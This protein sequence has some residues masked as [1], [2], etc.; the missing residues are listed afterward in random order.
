[1]LENWRSS[2][3]DNFFVADRNLQRLLEFYWGEKDYRAA[4]PD[5][6]RFGRVSATI[7][8]EAAR[9]SNEGDHLPQLDR[10][11][12]IGER[13]EEVD[14]HPSYHVAGRAIYGS[15]VMSVYQESGK[16][17]HSLA[18]FYLSGLNGEA[19][20]NCPLAMTAGLIKVLQAVGSPALQE[21]Y[22]PR[23]LEDDYDNG[24]SGAQFLTEVQG[25]SDVGANATVATPLDPAAEGTW[26]LNG[27]KWFCSN[28]TADL[29]LVTARVP[30][31]GEG[32]AGLGLFLAPRRLENGDLN[33]IYFRRLK[34]KLGTRSLATGEVEFDDALAYQ[35][36]DVD[37]G[38]RHA[39]IYVINTS[40]IFNGV[41]DGLLIWLREIMLT[42]G[43]IAPEDVDLLMLANTPEEAAQL[44]VDAL[45]DGGWREEQEERALAAT[46]QVYQKE[47][48]AFE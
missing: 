34:D 13:I 41:G 30:G 6:Y 39:M 28:L 36:G 24:Y 1:M 23:L 3:P 43:K 45:K 32:T 42:Q 21:R 14:Y 47:N 46:R 27:E 33:N 12:G 20:H 5:F 26:L 40:R 19:G 38:F 7:L 15:G 37:D 4:L 8:D 11:D 25:G 48:Y 44:V 2:Q 29:A 10:Y 9:V 31:Q 18:L 35:V 17:L 22:L 16:N